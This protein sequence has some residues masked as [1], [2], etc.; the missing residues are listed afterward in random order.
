MKGSF[1]DRR[2]PRRAERIAAILAALTAGGLFVAGVAFW[3]DGPSAWQAAA[4]L[5]AS[6]AGVGKLV[7]FAALSADCRLSPWTL[8]VAATIAEVGLAAILVFHLDLLFRIRRVGPRL[9]AI[10]AQSVRYL[11]AH[12]WLR[13][14]AGVGVAI[15]TAL[16]FSGTGPLGSTFFGEVAGLPPRTLLLG[17]AAGSVASSALM[18]LGTVALERRMEALIRHPIMTVLG[19]A[20]TLAFLL[21][22]GRAWRRTG[23]AEGAETGG[24]EPE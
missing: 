17:I 23:R 15:Y 16:P 5:G 22:L 19:V 9:L 2:I 7:I 21:L 11:R 3:Q 18:A 20:L 8:A 13:R 14:L 4:F 10:R 24:A 1:G 12:R 6:A